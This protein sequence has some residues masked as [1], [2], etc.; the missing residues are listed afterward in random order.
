MEWSGEGEDGDGGGRRWLLSGS[1][2]G[3]NGKSSDVMRFAP[4][5]MT[6]EEVVAC[7]GK[8]VSFV[9]SRLGGWREQ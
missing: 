3:T 5:Q 7:R 6:G 4:I 2:H 1:N 9:F 8:V